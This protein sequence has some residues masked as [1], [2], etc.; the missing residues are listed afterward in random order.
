MATGMAVLYAKR[1]LPKR[2]TDARNPWLGWI[3]VGSA[4]VVT[5]VGMVLTGVALGWLPAR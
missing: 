3:P 2:K 5:L 4:A 1:I